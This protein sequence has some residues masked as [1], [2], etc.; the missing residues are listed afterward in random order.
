MIGIVIFSFLIGRN[1]LLKESGLCT[2]VSERACRKYSRFVGAGRLDRTHNS[3]RPTG[4]YHKI[5]TKENNVWYNAASWHHVNCSRVRQCV[6]KGELT[7]YLVVSSPKPISL[8]YY[9]VPQSNPLF[10]ISFPN[11]IPLF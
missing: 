10:H 1:Y 2:S 9:F 7:P 5:T 8:F 11:P 4:C 3:L 6:C